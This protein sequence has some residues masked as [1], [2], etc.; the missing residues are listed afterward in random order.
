MTYLLFVSLLT[1]DG[2]PMVE[3]GKKK[4][5]EIA[6]ERKL[7]SDQKSFRCRACRPTYEQRTGEFGLNDGVELGAHP[8]TGRREGPEVMQGPRRDS[9]TP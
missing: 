4:K 1:G 9:F 7:P 8:N 6:G 3:E 5:K 2:V